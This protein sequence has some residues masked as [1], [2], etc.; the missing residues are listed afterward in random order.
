MSKSSGFH[1]DLGSVD[2]DRPAENILAASAVIVGRHRGKSAPRN[3]ATSPPVQ[4][5][6][7]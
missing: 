6:L 2:G 3:I 4:N 1:D 5:S 7:P